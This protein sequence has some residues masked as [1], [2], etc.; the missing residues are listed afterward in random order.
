[1]AGLRATPPLC[2]NRCGHAHPAIS[3][4]KDHSPTERNVLIKHRLQIIRF[5]AD[6]SF[7]FVVLVWQGKDWTG[8]RI[9]GGR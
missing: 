1:M 3:P 2:T 9:E 7:A 5:G 4:F 8:G 6:V